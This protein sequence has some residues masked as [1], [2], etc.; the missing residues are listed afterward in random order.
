LTRL[1]RTSGGNPF[2]A[3]E[4]LRS[5]GGQMPST[6]DE[7]PIPGSLRELVAV[8]LAALPLAAREAV[9]GTFALSRPTPAAIESALQAARRSQG[10]LTAAVEADALELRRGLVQLRHPLIGSTLYDE[11]TPS[12]R[13]AVHAR[14]AGIGRDPEEQA[15]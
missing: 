8:R 6:A 4:I 10:G 13:R 15:A 3:L 2:F 12:K 11:L 7:L 5:L 9:L 14:L 1:L